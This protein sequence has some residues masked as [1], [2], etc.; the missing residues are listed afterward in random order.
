M[1]Y[2]GCPFCGAQPKLEVNKVG[3]RDEA[4]LQARLYC[5]KGHAQVFAYHDSESEALANSFMYTTH[6]KL[7][8]HMG[9]WRASL[10]AL[11]ST[12]CERW[13]TRS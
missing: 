7:P 9:W 10:L 5:E 1:R 13:N 2:L 8:K 12:L 6:P 4:Y 11:E 3:C